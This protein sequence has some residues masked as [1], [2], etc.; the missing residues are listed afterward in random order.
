MNS[1]RSRIKRKLLTQL[2]LHDYYS[3]NTPNNGTTVAGSVQNAIRSDLLG[4]ANFNM[5]GVVWPLLGQTVCVLL[6]HMASGH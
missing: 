6:L 4:N 3:N 2:C 5:E 1:I